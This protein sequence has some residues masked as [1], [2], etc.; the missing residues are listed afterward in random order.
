MAVSPRMAICSGIILPEAVFNQ[1]QITNIVFHIVEHS[2]ESTIVRVL[3]TQ[4]EVHSLRLRNGRWRAW[5]ATQFRCQVHSRDCIQTR[6]DSGP[7][8]ATSCANSSERRITSRFCGMSAAARRFTCKFPRSNSL[9]GGTERERGNV[10]YAVMTS[11]DACF[12]RQRTWCHRK[13]NFAGGVVG[14]TAKTKT[15]GKRNAIIGDL[16]TRIL[17]RTHPSL[18]WNCKRTRVRSISS[19]F[20]F[21]RSIAFYGKRSYRNKYVNLHRSN[22][23]AN[24]Q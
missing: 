22:L 20:L 9:R 15:D 11:M 19:Q 5:H 14:A 21:H 7:V 8:L 6:T 4:S 13:R 1:Q 3:Q 23:R 18:R 16:S 12:M 17:R 24:G 2:N 10:N